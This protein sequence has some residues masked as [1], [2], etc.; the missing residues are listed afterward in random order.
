MSQ[1]KFNYTSGGEF[2]LKGEN[3]V[4]YFNVNELGDAYTGRY[5]SE[6]SDI[7]LTPV[8]V[9]SA[10]Y[11]RSSNFRDRYVY[12]TLSLP[13]SLDSILIQPSELVNY[14]SI[15]SKIKLLHDNM[16]YLHSKMFMGDTNTPT[17][18]NYYVFCNPY[19]TKEIE[20]K[21]KPSTFGSIGEWADDI[22]IAT[23]AINPNKDLSYTKLDELKKFVIIPT[24]TNSYSIFGITNTFL[25]GLTSS[26][27]SDLSS[28]I[29][30]SSTK[31]TYYKNV[32]DNNTSEKCQNL[33]DIAYN[34]RYLYVTDSDINGGGQVFKYDVNSYITNDPVFNGD[35]YLIETIGGLGTLSDTTKFNRCTTLGKKDDE[36]YVYD[37]GNDCVKIFD[38]NFVWKSTIKLPSLYKYVILDIKYRY[39]NNKIYFL[40]KI[41]DGKLQNGTLT[42]KYGLL[43]YDSN[44][45]QTNNYVFE[46]VLTTDING[47]ETEQFVSFEF[48]EQDSNVFYVAS[49]NTIYKKFVTKPNS[50]AFSTFTTDMFYPVGSFIWNSSST[51]KWEEMTT[52]TW[53]GSKANVALTDILIIPE[54]ETSK[55]TKNIDNLFVMAE[56]E[57]PTGSLS[58]RAIYH[59]KETTNYNSVLRDT[60]LKYYNYKK[61]A[62]DKN[63]YIQSI[64]LNKEFFKLFSNIVQFKN[65]LKGRFFFEYGED[66]ELLIR[67]ILYFTDDEINTLT[68]EL[69]YNCYVNDNELVQP[70][71]INRMLRKLYKFQEN[72]VELTKVKIRNLK[73]VANAGKLLPPE[74]SD[75]LVID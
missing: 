15:N 25:I 11:Y 63:E 59:F 62:L 5:Y 53:N 67:D 55:Y 73:K 65:T 66:D 54:D 29:V 34:G 58:G 38:S 16:I 23:D 12:D 45:I 14:A 41:N 4:G 68:V 36:L 28:D 39:L 32:I 20:W 37:E 72:V 47:A 1:T 64:V 8:S 19:E 43:E 10:D 61:I 18:K 2:T 6:L 27:V 74:Y 21:Q 3:Y 51:V 71:V 40:Y 42:Y 50:P 7:L 69:E 56:F 33:Q 13:N 44:L 26:R 9:Y 46:D 75:T 24:T 30:L 70:N 60:N 49:T 48:S 35:I 31:V 17:D 57:I 22:Y 52:K